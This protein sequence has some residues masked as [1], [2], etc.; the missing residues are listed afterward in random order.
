MTAGDQ[1]QYVKYYGIDND[2]W[3]ESFGGFSNLHTHL[4]REYISEACSTTES[5]EASVTH[6]FLYP[7]HIKKTYFIE[8]VIEGEICLAA[9][10][11]ESTVTSY[12]VSV[13]K[14]NID[15]TQKELATTGWIVV[16]DTLAWDG[17]LS[18][19]DEMVYHFYINV[20]EEKKLDENDRI[21]VKIEVNCNYCTHLMH[22]NDETWTDIWVDIP[23]RL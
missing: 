1:R 20:W 14:M 6:E 5:S 18:I 12:R 8:G 21:F 7:H 9:N 17:G 15:T 23:F 11:C 19:G 10:G 16:N 4:V 3:A 2:D 22:S 13:C